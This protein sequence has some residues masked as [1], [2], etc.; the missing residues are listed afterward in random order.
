M[1]LEVEREWKRS[2]NVPFLRRADSFNVCNINIVRS[3]S[4]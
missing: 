2:S 1:Y 3:G 4:N